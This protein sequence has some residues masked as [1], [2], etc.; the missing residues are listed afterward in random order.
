VEKQAVEAF[1]GS[2]L[3][4]KKVPGKWDCLKCIER[5]KPALKNRTWKD[6]KNYVHN[7]NYKRKVAE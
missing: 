6:V 4:S 3:L 7:K 1:L 2:F 5:S